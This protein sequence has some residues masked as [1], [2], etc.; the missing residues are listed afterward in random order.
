MNKKFGYLIVLVVIALSS[1][2]CSISVPDVNIN[3]DS[4]KGSGTSSEET[5]SLEGITGVNLSSIGN[6]T[7]VYGSE[8]KIVINADDN[9]IPYITTEV[10]NGILDIGTQDGINIRPVEKITYNLTVT[11]PLELLKVSGLGDINAPALESNEMSI[12]VSGSGNI[13]IQDL[14]VELIQANISGLGSI[15]IDEGSATKQEIT[16]S[17]SGTYKAEDIQSQSANVTVSGLGNASLWVT[18]QLTA[19]ISGSG[20]V[21]YYGN[22]RIQQTVSGIGGLVSKGNK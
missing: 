2:A 13:S 18:D 1:L 16:L 14:K 4:V 3:L 15:T 21:E 8:E 10:K 12:Q 7:I 20:N 11:K 9:L 6:L 19:T 5:R 17:G 22:P